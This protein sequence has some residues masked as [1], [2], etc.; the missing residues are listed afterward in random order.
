MWLPS[1]IHEAY[2]LFKIISYHF[3]ES[4]LLFGGPQPEK[5]PPMFTVES[6][7]EGS[8][9]S[10]IEALIKSKQ[11]EL[12][13][14]PDGKQLCVVRGDHGRKLEWTKLGEGRHSSY[15]VRDSNGQVLAESEDGSE[16]KMTDGGGK[17][18]IGSEPIVPQAQ[19]ENHVPYVD[20][21]RYD[22]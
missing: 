11:G 5:M 6:E 7:D 10:S 12:L 22:A 8:L 20:Q 21:S 15:I 14:L 18:V 4:Q 2:T 19:F 17:C 13:N 9:K 16:W 3:M 1:S